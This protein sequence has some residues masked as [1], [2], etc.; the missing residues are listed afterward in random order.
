MRWLWRL[1]RWLAGLAVFLF[2][3]LGIVF[4][5]MA[6]INIQDARHVAGAVATVL[7]NHH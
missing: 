5:L 2:L 6:L 3:V 4:A 1:V 7:A